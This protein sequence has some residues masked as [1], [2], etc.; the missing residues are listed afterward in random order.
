MKISPADSSR[1]LRATSTS[2]GTPNRCASPSSVS[3]SCTS[4]VGSSF[5][6]SESCANTGGPASEVAHANRQSNG[7]NPNRTA[8]PRMSMVIST[9]CINLAWAVSGSRPLNPSAPGRL[10]LLVSGMDTWVFWGPC[11]VGGWVRPEGTNPVT[12][13]CL[14][15]RGVGPC[16]DATCRHRSQ[17]SVGVGAR[18]VPATRFK[19]SWLTSVGSNLN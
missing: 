14:H 15:V 13:G 18:R 3:P 7:I 4:Y 17:E 9:S 6:S 19:C 16:L 10:L 5:G 11:H 12:S 1:L 2:T 8:K